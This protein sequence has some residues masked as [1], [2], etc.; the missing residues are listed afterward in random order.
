MELDRN[1][2]AL[3]LNMEDGQAAMPLHAH[4]AVLCRL[5]AHTSCT[6]TEARGG[7]RHRQGR[8][9]RPQALDR[10]AA[11]G[12][13]AAPRLIMMQLVK[14]YAADRQGRHVRGAGRGGE[15]PHGVYVSVPARAARLRGSGGRSDSF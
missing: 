9:G 13:L 8:G 6:G 4:D 15:R 7:R 10:C 1:D 11:G 14:G 2:G 3:D 12:R 5:T